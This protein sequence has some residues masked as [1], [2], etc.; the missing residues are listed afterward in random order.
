MSHELII[1]K[2]LHPFV[3]HVSENYLQP[4]F[5][6]LV[7]LASEVHTTTKTA[8]NNYKKRTLATAHAKLLKT[9]LPTDPSAIIAE[10]LIEPD[11]SSEKHI[12]HVYYNTSADDCQL[13][14]SN[15]DMSKA[16]RWTTD[17]CKN[18]SILFV[19]LI[20]IL[21][22]LSIYAFLICSAVKHGYW[23]LL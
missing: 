1:D 4:S 5:Y 2:V 6:S 9:I 14:A 23:F 8:V 18:I 15:I 13:C 20:L 16:T 3:S 17:F 7:S 11:E 21:L 12:K 19:S 10:Y 22:C